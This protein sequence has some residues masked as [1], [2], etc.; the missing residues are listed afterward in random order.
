MRNFM[1]SANFVRSIFML[2]G[3]LCVVAHAEELQ[4]TQVSVSPK[5]LTPKVD[6]AAI[7]FRLNKKASVSVKIYDA[8][9]VMVWRQQADDLP[10]GNHQILWPAV[11]Q[12]GRAVEPEAY[13]FVLEAEA[14]S[15]ERVTY[16][17]TDIT[18]G[19]SLRV[20]DAKY[21]PKTKRVQL[22]APGLGR[23]FIRAGISQSFAVNTLVNNQIL[24]EGKQEISWDGFD[25]SHAFSV[26]GHPKLIIGGFGYRLSE[27]AIVVK[28][29]EPSSAENAQ[30]LHW[31]TIG[32]DV[33]RRASS[34]SQRANADPGFYRSVERN[35][36]V[37]LKLVFPPDIRHSSAGLPI[38]EGMTSVRV[39]LA[40]EDAEVMES[41][42]GEMV[43]F[44]DSQ[45]IYD[46]EVS[47]YPYTF[48]WRPPVLDGKPHMLTAFVAGFGGNIAMATV[49]VQLGSDQAQ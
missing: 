43:F 1:F 7:S 5:I 35:R 44:W 30:K 47:Y 8:R 25:V 34:K 36:D 24:L 16:D 17:L 15:G 19:E 41:Q 6:A 20:D 13:Y 48:N 14:G 21:D 29:P 22:T 9:D 49:Q 26:A 28:S 46:N 40:P 3:W 39:E 4:I 32:E 2:V 11:D 45:L 38:V 23:Y 42:R 12:S 33:E 10:S 18:G 27:N 31:T 37:L